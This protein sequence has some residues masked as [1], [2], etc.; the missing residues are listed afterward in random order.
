VTWRHLLALPAAVGFAVVVGT[1][2]ASAAESHTAKCTA[3]K[4]R[5]DATVKYRKVDSDLYI[6]SV[7]LTIDD[8][9]GQRNRV[10]LAV[11]SDNKTAF[12]YT[13]GPNVTAGPYLFDY[14]DS[15]IK[16]TPPNGAEI[17]VEVTV[18]FDTKGSSQTSCTATVTI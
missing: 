17:Q 14:S 13:S 1:V 4:Y 10:R 2:P 15:P 9:A 5:A 16:I 3:D 6:G 12:T 8:R 11:Q 18:E 7:A